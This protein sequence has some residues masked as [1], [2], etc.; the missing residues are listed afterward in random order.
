MRIV[1]IIFVLIGIFIASLSILPESITHYKKDENKDLGLKPIKNEIDVYDKLGVKNIKNEIDN[2]V[3]KLKNEPIKN[4]LEKKEENK[5]TQDEI[6][7]HVINWELKG[8]QKNILIINYEIENLTNELITNKNKII[9]CIVKNK[10]IKKSIQ[11]E[12]VL[13]IKPKDKIKINDFLIDFVNFDTDSVDC[14]IE[15]KKQEKIDLSFSLNKNKKQEKEIDVLL[16]P[17][18]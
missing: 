14:T 7:F 2:S 6:Y 1:F 4:I 16:P 18:N 10:D 9:N 13:N 17:I 8:Q 3:E 11:K 5:N 12:M 15:N